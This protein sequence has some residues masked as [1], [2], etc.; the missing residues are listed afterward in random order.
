MKKLL[1]AAVAVSV[2]L[3]CTP[4]FADKNDKNEVESWLDESRYKYSSLCH[5]NS[6]KTKD[7]LISKNY[8]RV[9]SEHHHSW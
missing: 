4:A 1:K 8:L 7:Y 3:A 6:A 9:K 5:Y 2:A